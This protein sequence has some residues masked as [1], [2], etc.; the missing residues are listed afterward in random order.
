MAQAYNVF[1]VAS[2]ILRLAAVYY[3]P[4]FWVRLVV[5][6]RHGTS[7]HGL[8]WPKKARDGP[9]L[10]PVG[11]TLSPSWVKSAPNYAQ[12]GQLSPNWPQVCRSC[13]KL[14]PSWPQMAP[15]WPRV[16]PSWP[17]VGPSWPQVGP[18]FAQ[19]EAS[20]AQLGHIK[21]HSK[22]TMV[23]GRGK[24]ELSCAMLKPSWAILRH[25]GATLG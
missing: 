1:S 8:N 14:A 10:A 22:I 19:V 24:L 9:K 21:K 25:L 11:P 4:C 18:E 7:L 12:V 13:P 2:P 3:T 20:W 16:G 23:L 17:Q 15:S 5:D 6:P